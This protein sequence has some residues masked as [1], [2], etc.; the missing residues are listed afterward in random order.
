MIARIILTLVLLALLGPAD[1]QQFGP[2]QFAIKDDDGDPMS[3]HSLSADQMAQVAGLPGL[4][5][6]GGPKGDVTLYQFYDLNCPFC[7]EAAADVDAL[8][9]GDRTLR[10]VFVPYPV[11]SA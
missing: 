10:L 5:D 9:R 8:I 7:K 1:A 2:A 3:N 6:V 11:L 4:V